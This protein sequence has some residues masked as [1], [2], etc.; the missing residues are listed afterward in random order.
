MGQVSAYFRGLELLAP[1]MDSPGHS[2]MP[3]LVMVVKERA[4]TWMVR[5]GAS[6]MQMYMRVPAL[7]TMLWAM[8]T[9]VAAIWAAA[10]P[11]VAMLLPRSFDKL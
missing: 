1:L 5:L 11:A 7:C 2:R 3:S 4:R 6:T 9:G 10:A 8:R